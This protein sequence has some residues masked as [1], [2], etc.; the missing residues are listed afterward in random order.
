[1]ANIKHNSN[2]RATI[3]SGLKNLNASTLEQ[4]P[5]TQWYA[6][7]PANQQ[8]SKRNQVCEVCEWSTTK[9][10]KV[11]RE[12]IIPSKAEQLAIDKIAK[13]NL[14]YKIVLPKKKSNGRS[15]SFTS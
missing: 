9:F 3:K 15:R 13:V 4:V 1:M 11:K 5:F 6:S 2:N 8:I 7:L 14:T 12:E 10:Y